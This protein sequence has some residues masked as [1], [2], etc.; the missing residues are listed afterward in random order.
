MPIVYVKGD[1]TRPLGSGPRVIVHCVNDIGKW[2]SG[3]VLAL[4]KRWPTVGNRY[5]SWHR[6]P[7]LDSEM[8]KARA[9]FIL[10]V[11]QAG[12]V[13]TD[14]E[15]AAVSRDWNLGRN[16]PFHLGAVQFVEA[17]PALWVA[18]LVGQHRTIQDGER[19]PIRYEALALGFQTIATFCREHMASVHAPRLGAGLARGNW[20]QIAGLL[21]RE[22]V[23]R[24]I[25]V[26]VYELSP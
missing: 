6:G 20:T 25:P 26:T 13:P 15:V 8:R 17:E 14:E 12:V 18:N 5:R 22:V 24:G 16:P 11:A 4:D 19:I 2:G 10:E 9:A 3:F 1:A 7:Q 23:A 21:E